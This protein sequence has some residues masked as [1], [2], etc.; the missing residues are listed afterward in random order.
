MKTHTIKTILHLIMK[1]KNIYS[2]NVKL[3]LQRS[4][5][6]EPTKKGRPGKIIHQYYSS[7]CN[8]CEHKTE[9]TKSTTRVISDYQT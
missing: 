1:T 6:Q 7:E 5:R 9:C 4:Q 3:P 2:L 8:E